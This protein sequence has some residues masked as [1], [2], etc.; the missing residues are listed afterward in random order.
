M[1]DAE[2]SKTPMEWHIATG[3]LS[4]ITPSLWLDILSVIASI[5]ERRSAERRPRYASIITSASSQFI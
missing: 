2:P 4:F 1:F 3:S 5:A